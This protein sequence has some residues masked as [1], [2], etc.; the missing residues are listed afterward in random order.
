MTTQKE[1]HKNTIQN[2]DAICE[3]YSDKIKNLSFPIYSSYDIRDS[4]YKVTNVDANIYPA[5]FNNICPVDQENLPDLFQKYLKAHYSSDLKKILLITEEHTQNPYYLD[6]VDTITGV[7]REAG[8]QVKV[9]FPSNLENDLVLESAKGKKVEITSGGIDSLIWNEYR[10]DLVISNND[11]SISHEEWGT[12]V[13]VPLNPP[14]EMGWYQRK[15]SRYFKHYNQLVEDFSKKAGLDPFTMRVETEAFENFDINNEGSRSALADKVNEFIS[16]LQKSYKERG[17]EQKPF[18]FVKN[19]SGTY[20]LAVIKV[21]SPDEVKDWGYKSRKKMKAAKGGRDVEEVIIQEGIPS[22]IQAGTATAEPVIYMVGCELGGGFLRTH[23][24]KDP[25]ESL[26]SPGALY[27]R[28]CMSDLLVKPEQCPMENVYGW[29][30]KLGLLAIGME[31]QE[32]QV[33]YQ[34]FINA[35]CG[36]KDSK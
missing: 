21:N 19:N 13:K 31:A 30:A 1:L 2:K 23:A 22:I 35:P 34:G 10:P 6:N 3:W 8:Y 25:T 15:K 32:M 36:G 33:K 28:L 14:R 20:G 4:G 12:Q 26:N 16:G 11:F 7:L 5:G 24:E 18:V 27:K 17:I 29:S 9:A